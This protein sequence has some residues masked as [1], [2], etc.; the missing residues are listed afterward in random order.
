MLVGSQPA[1]WVR[2]GSPIRIVC[3]VILS[4]CA[5]PVAWQED[6]VMCCF[7]PWR[8]LHLRFVSW[9]TTFVGCR[10]SRQVNAPSRR[11]VALPFGAGIC[12]CMRF[13]RQ[14]WGM[15]TRWSTMCRHGIE[16]DRPV[17]LSPMSANRRAGALLGSAT[18]LFL[19]K[20]VAVGALRR[21]WHH[22]C[23]QLDLC[24]ACKMR[25]RGLWPHQPTSAGTTRNVLDH[26]AYSVP[27]T[28]VC[29]ERCIFFFS[30]MPRG[31]NLIANPCR[32]V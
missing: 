21:A 7:E 25:P 4:T 28:F 2:P 19:C 5:R 17:L 16:D 14:L 27:P 6:G 20:N 1:G 13:S 15:S 31:C 29:W 24:A 10:P 22:T 8:L 23:S 32:T 11:I 30:C 26:C 9:G 3:K 12:I 18:L